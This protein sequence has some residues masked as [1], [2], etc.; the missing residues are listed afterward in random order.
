M[1]VKHNRMKR[2]GPST[3]TRYFIEAQ[4]YVAEAMQERTSL[5]AFVN[6]WKKGV[7]GQWGGGLKSVRAL[8]KSGRQMGIG[9]SRYREMPRRYHRQRDAGLT[10][11]EQQHLPFQHKQNSNARSG[12]VT[13]PSPCSLSSD[14]GPGSKSRRKKHSPTLRGRSHSKDGP[15][16]SSEAI[17]QITAM[18]AL[19]YYCEYRMRLHR[20][21]K[22]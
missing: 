16:S 13:L 20:I 14:S 21:S 5:S 2:I 12:L 11:L 1:N 8:P 6:E 15:T 22:L 18:K 9:C 17:H 3:V 4:T 19:N 7:E 10:A